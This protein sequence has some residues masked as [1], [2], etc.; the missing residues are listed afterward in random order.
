MPVQQP[1]PQPAAHQIT[2]HIAHNGGRGRGGDENPDIQFVAGAR[3]GGR[4]NQ[5]RFTRNGHPHA[6]KRVQAHDGAIA[7]GGNKARDLVMGEDQHENL[8]KVRARGGATR[9][10]R[11][12]PHRASPCNS[13][14]ALLN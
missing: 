4:H 12:G 3:I 8:L 11:A 13:R 2:D 9:S 5:R 6:L 1:E 10:W 7:I 14:G